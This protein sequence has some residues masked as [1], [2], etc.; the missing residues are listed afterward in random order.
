MPQHVET[1]SKK[2]TKRESVNF[3]MH[4]FRNLHVAL[5]GV[6]TKGEGSRLDLILVKGSGKR[7]GY[8]Q[9]LRNVTAPNGAEKRCTDI[10]N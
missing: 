10:L 8:I 1:V 3:D 4:P 6:K 2:F 7:R 9:Y 5:Q